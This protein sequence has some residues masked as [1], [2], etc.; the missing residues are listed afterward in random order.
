MIIDERPKEVEIF[1]GVADESSNSN[2]IDLSSEY[3]SVIFENLFERAKR[4]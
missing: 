3:V 4:T 2:K 1:E